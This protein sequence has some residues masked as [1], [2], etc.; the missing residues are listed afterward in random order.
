MWTEAGLQQ[1]LIS[2]R[3]AQAGSTCRCTACPRALCPP[4]QQ[5]AR[6]SRRHSVCTGSPVPHTL[7]EGQQRLW[8]DVKDCSL[9]SHF[10]HFWQTWAPPLP[11]LKA[12]TALTSE[13]GTDGRRTFCFQLSGSLSDLADSQFSPL[14]RQHTVAIR[15]RTLLPGKSQ[16]QRK[17]RLLV[18]RQKQQW[19]QLLLCEPCLCS[20]GKQN[21]AYEEEDANAQSLSHSPRLPP[22]SDDMEDIRSPCFCNSGNSPEAPCR[23]PCHPLCHVLWACSI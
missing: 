2:I 1:L 9:R 23:I 10:L 13:T 21:G 12:T 14:R 16:Q 6:G 19:C 18:H 4:S 3:C 17:Y 8:G 7:G 11:L 20:A 15:D 5:P 22:I